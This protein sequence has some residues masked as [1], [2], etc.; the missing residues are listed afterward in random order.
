[1]ELANAADGNPLAN[2]EYSPLGELSRCS[3]PIARA[4]FLRF[5]TKY[6]DDETDLLGYAFRFSSASLGRFLSRDKVGELAFATS[7]G[8]SQK[9]SG[10][11]QAVF[12]SRDGGL[13]CQARNDFLNTIDPLG[14]EAECGTA[15]VDI[16][17]NESQEPFNAGEM[18]TE[19]RAIVPEG[20]GVYWK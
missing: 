3:G 5:S 13:Y 1:M 7:L 6:Q 19:L 2:Y 18:L 11:K 8:S 16:F 20:A 15:T 4:N 10:G 17:I 12:G 9:Y 14:L